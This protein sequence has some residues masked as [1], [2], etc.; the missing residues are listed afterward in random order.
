MGLR[1]ALGLA[2]T[3]VALLVATPSAM[4]RGGFDL[5]FRF[6]ASHGYAIEIGGYD[7]TAI[8]EAT[9]IDRAS[10]RREWSAYVVRG[11][12]SP[13]A[14]HADFGT[15]ASAAMRF[16]P[17]GRV[18]YGKRH[19]DCV[20]ADRYTTRY[21]AFVG[22]VRFRGEGGYASATV[23]RVKG[24]VVTPRRLA[25]R[26]AFSER[27]RGEQARASAGDAA[28]VTKLEAFMRSGLTAMFFGA[29]RSD[30]RTRFLAEIEQTLG[31]LGIVRGVSVRASLAAFTADSALGSAAAS[32][33]APFTGSAAFQRS[34][35]GAKSW[36][37]DLAVSFPGASNVSLTDPRLKTQLTRSW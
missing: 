31:S 25:C 30:G 34:P 20:G 2:L 17:S 11:Q 12:V 21:G 19:R 24:K 8:A 26:D 1:V 13:T 7:A 4:A 10:G 37:G 35:A 5:S 6:P 28:K 16:R 36:T 22:S 14:I 29:L 27:R 23:H 9:R 32:P 33:P 18:T 15:V 3:G